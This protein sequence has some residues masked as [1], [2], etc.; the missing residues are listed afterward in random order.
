MGDRSGTARFH[1][2]QQFKTTTTGASPHR[3]LQSRGLPRTPGAAS[4]PPRA[5]ARARTRPRAAGSA[6]RRPA[7]H[8]FPAGTRDPSRSGPGRTKATP[9]ARPAAAPRSPAR[10]HLG[11]V[12]GGGGGSSAGLWRRGPGG[13]GD[14]NSHSRPGAC[15]ALG[16][17][18]PAQRRRRG[19]RSRRRRRRRR[20][21]RVGGGASRQVQVRPRRRR[22]A[23][24][25]SRPRAGRLLR[26]GPG[27]QAAAALGA[28]RSAG[29][30]PSA[31][32]S[33][34]PA[35]A[36]AG[37]RRAREQPC[38]GRRGRPGRHSGLR[39]GGAGG[40]GCGSRGC[41]AEVRSCHRGHLVALTDKNPPPPAPARRGARA[42]FPAPR[43]PPTGSRPGPWHVTPPHLH[44]GGP[45]G[46]SALYIPAPPPR[47]PPR[48][49]GWSRPGHAPSFPLNTRPRCGS[50]DR[51]GS[52][53]GCE[54]ARALP[55]WARAGTRGSRPAWDAWRAARRPSESWCCGSALAR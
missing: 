27:S 14:N 49:I 51:A 12:P 28:R 46:Q 55:A 31:S 22:D 10:A 17:R 37:A 4:L 44:T 11:S 36:A 15:G 25:S 47:A 32:G 1:Q 33:G 48:P 43:W 9:P 38:R 26:R 3:P 7:P 21:G 19:L 29:C 42:P 20:R 2:L 39:G 18:G 8:T 23:P 54:R 24:S 35:A 53:P 45:T 5:R 30:A 34:G 52:A 16:R 50:P 13:G 40:G 6:S 41:R